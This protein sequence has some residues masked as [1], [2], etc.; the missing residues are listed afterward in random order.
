[1]MIEVIGPERN[2]S[3]LAFG[4]IRILKKKGKAGF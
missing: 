4:V 1:M 3:Y 2:G